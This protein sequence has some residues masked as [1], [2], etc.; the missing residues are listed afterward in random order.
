MSQQFSFEFFPPR[1]A[2]AWPAFESTVGELAKLD[3]AYVSVTFGAGGSMQGG[4]PEAVKTIRTKWGLQTAPHISCVNTSPDS[5]RELLT[6]YRDAGVNRLVV[7]RGD[8]PSGSG[9]PSGEFRYAADLVRFIR[10]ETGDEFHIEVAAYPEM[11]PQARTPD[12]DLDCFVAKVNEGANAAITQYFFSAEAFFDFRERVRQRGCEV[13][14]VPGIMPITNHRQLVRFSSIC[15]AEIPRWIKLRLE[16]YDDDLPSIRAFGEEVITRLCELLL[17]GGVPG[18]HFYT[19]NKV[20]PTQV[21]WR[22]LGLGQPAVD[23]SAL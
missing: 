20:E 17:E 6:V 19:L 3:P 11:H 8:L 23:A 10:A 9:L 22:N 16:Q 12:R 15:G 2:D 14:I 13:P 7:L 5:I 4:T 21:L 1:G 18:L